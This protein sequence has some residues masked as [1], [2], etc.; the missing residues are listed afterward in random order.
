M[1]EFQAAELSDEPCFCSQ[2]EFND[3]PD[4]LCFNDGVRKI[5]FVLVYEDE[6]KKEFEKRHAYQR[7]KVGFSF[8]KPVRV[9]LFCVNEQHTV[10]SFSLCFSRSDSLMKHITDRVNME[11]KCAVLIQ[12]KCIVLFYTH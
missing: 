2:A 4:S 12:T 6:D 5:D 11:C 9:V 1:Y 3:K 7:R 10:F 8:L